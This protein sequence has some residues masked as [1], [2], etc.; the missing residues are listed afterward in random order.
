MLKIITK[1]EI[2]VNGFSIYFNASIPLD[3][4]LSYKSIYLMR[5]NIMAKPKKLTF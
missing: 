5:I 2:Y 1:L 4:F 3:Q